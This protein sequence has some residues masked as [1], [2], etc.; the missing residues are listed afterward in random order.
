MQRVTIVTLEDSKAILCHLRTKLARWFLVSTTYLRG[1]T[2]WNSKLILTKLFNWSTNWKEHNIV[3]ESLED[4][5]VIFWYLRFGH[6]EHWICWTKS[7]TC[8]I[9]LNCWNRSLLNLELIE[10]LYLLRQFSY[11]IGEA[12]IHRCNTAT[13]DHFLLRWWQWN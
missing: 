12:S 7:D 6:L 13:K 2:N 9:T 3:I 1:I 10:K 11:N 4:S 5:K 8:I